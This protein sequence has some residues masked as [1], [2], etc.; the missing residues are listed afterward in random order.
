M[1]GAKGR[2]HPRL[3][4]FFPGLVDEQAV[5]RPSGSPSVKEEEDKATT[6]E[7]EGVQQLQEALK[8]LEKESLSWNT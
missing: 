1:G 2:K 8:I 7:G 5:A 4:F 6:A 3:I